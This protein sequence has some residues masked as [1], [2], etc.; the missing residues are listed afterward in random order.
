MHSGLACR[1]RG[2]SHGVVR[3][4]NVAQT[5][6]VG[7]WPWA[8]EP[9]EAARRRR[10]AVRACAAGAC[11]G[12]ALRAS[13]SRAVRACAPGDHDRAS[14]MY[15]YI[16]TYVREEAG[17][18]RMQGRRALGRRAQACSGPDAHTKGASCRPPPAASCRIITIIIKIIIKPRTSWHQVRS[19]DPECT[20][21]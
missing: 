21:L 14:T 10:R 2:L 13:G 6:C 19:R 8:H 7:V 1:T 9:L 18:G 11:A 15:I 3:R 17:R 16:Y 20:M 12:A 4:G 5:P